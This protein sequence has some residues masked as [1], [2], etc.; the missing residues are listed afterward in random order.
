MEESQEQIKILNMKIQAL[1]QTYEK[2]I[3]EA[4]DDIK[5]HY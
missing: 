3:S 1:S 4:R 2:T 5:A